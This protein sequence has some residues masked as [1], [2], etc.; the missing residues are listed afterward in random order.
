MNKLRAYLNKP[1]D[2]IELL[3][4]LLVTVIFV[5]Y[6]EGC[7]HFGYTAYTGKLLQ[8]TPTSIVPIKALRTEPRDRRHN[9]LDN[10]EKVRREKQESV[11]RALGN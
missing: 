9:S 3:I 7:L 5:L 1:A 8:D 10:I 2:G 4:L 6:T 11:I